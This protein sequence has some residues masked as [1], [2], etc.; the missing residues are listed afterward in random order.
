MMTDEQRYLFDLQGFLVLKGVLDAATMQRM[1]ADM[2]AHGVTNPENDPTKSRFTGFLAWGADWRNL[3]DHPKLVPVLTEILGERFRMDHAYGMAARAAGEAGNFGMHHQAG[4][5]HHGCFYVSHGDK[6]HNGLIVVSFALSDTLPGAGGFGCIPGSHKALYPTPKH[7]YDADN[8]IIQQVPAQA[9]DAIIFTEALTHGTLR[10]TNAAQERRQILLKYCPHYMQWAGQPMD[11]NIDGL[12]ER[13]RLILQ[14][15][16]V[17]Q[18]ER[19]EAV[20]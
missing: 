19:V 1:H 13:Q 5:F 11:S 4:M 2:E 8:P 7:Y 3:I 14:G 6:M 9:G 12:T 10:W 18:R 20:N 16:Y 17:H 15:P